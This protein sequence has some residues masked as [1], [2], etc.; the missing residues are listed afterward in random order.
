[1]EKKFVGALFENALEVNPN[2]LDKNGSQ[3]CEP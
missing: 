3:P 2:K 1:M